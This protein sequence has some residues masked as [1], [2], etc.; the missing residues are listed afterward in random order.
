MAIPSLAAWGA[1]S[2]KSAVRAARAT[3]F[4][5]S[6]TAI[7]AAFAASSSAVTVGGKRDQY[8]RC[9]GHGRETVDSPPRTLTADAYSTYINAPH[10]HRNSLVDTGTICS[11]CIFSPVM[12]FT[13]SS[14][15]NTT[16][17]CSFSTLGHVSVDDNAVETS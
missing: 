10:V 11:F 5:R 8:V 1:L 17:P 16:S 6:V 15:E 7:A 9:D 2:A 13:T 4:R 3:P 14:P 12:S